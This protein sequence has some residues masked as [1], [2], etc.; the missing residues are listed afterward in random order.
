M[1]MWD[2]IKTL[3]NTACG[4]I[5]AGGKSGTVMRRNEDMWKDKQS[6]VK[7]VLGY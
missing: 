4:D 5:Q 1:A 3:Y 7:L 2:S 6:W